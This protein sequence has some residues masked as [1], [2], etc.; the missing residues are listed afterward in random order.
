[1]GYR[2]LMNRTIPPFIDCLIIGAGPAGIAAVYEARKRGIDPN[3]ILLIE[4]Q[5]MIAATI[6]D[7]YPEDKMVLSNYKGQLAQ[8][9]GDLCLRDMSKAEFIEY[10]QQVLKN[11]LVKAN[12]NEVVKSIKPLKNRQIMV[13]TSEETYLSNTV[14][15]AIGTLGTPR[16]LALPIPSELQDRII[17]DLNG[18]QSK[19]SHILVVGGGDS[20]SEFA[21]IL[22]SRSHR[23][24]LSY[25]KSDL[26]SMSE[27]NR[28]LLQKQIDEKKISFY[29]SSELKKLSPESTG[30]M[31]LLNTG[32]SLVVDKILLALGFEKP[33]GQLSLL[34]IELKCEEGEIFCE[35]GI[36]GLY[37]IGDLAQNT[38]GS[39]NL[40][41]NSAFKAIAR[42]CGSDLNCSL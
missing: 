16:K 1:M 40:A 17:F 6:Q 21:Q 41:F 35:S 42:A 26:T 3:K 34:G 22:S 25:R 36:E 39:I 32:E 15:V 4:K 13:E 10:L 19:D 2:L 31:V 29:P 33:K 38:G 28:V 18:I 9:F 7:K 5:S 12:F 14:F 37:V 30:A 23:V 27:T 8:C 20:A 24:S 11:S